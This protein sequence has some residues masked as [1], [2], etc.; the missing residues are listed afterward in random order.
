MAKEKRNRY[1]MLVDMDKCLG[2]KACTLACKVENN[3]DYDVFYNRMTSMGPVGEFPHL[4][5]FYFPRQ[6]QQCAD[7]EC[8]KV[9]PTKATYQTEDGIVLVD[10]DKCFG[11]QYCIWA[12]P[13]GARTKNSRTGMVEKCML[14]AHRDLEHGEQPACVV[15][16]EG[17]CRFF[18]DIDDPQSEI[19]Q[20]YAKNSDRA[21]TIHPE[22]GTDPQF[23]YLKP[24]K[25][26]S[27]L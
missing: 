8:V 6:C 11:C 13:Y 23:I 19:A 22:L 17:N 20:Y 5:Y 9:C 16:C 25:G 27:R 1:T 7:P 24:K 26:A 3:V 15:S 18:G 2:C 10:Q 21:F 12:C 14:C 4:D